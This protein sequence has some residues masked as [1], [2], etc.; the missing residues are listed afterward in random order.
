M[1]SENVFKYN[2]KINSKI[3]IVAN[4]RVL[5]GIEG[6]KGSCNSDLTV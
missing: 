6:S 3:I 4:P 1:G 2:R 5:L